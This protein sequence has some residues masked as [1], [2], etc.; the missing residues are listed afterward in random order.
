VLTS[1]LA[2]FTLARYIGD[3]IC[4]NPP[5]GLLFQNEI[6]AHEVDAVLTVVGNKKKIFIE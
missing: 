5:N 6:E 1:W 2:N 3:R 4:E